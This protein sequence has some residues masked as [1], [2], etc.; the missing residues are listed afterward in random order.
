MRHQWPIEKQPESSGGNRQIADLRHL[1]ALV[2]EIT[3]ESSP[4]ADALNEM[5]RFSSDYDAAPAI[6][7]RRFDAC[8]AETTE[9]AA[10]AVK[11]LNGSGASS[12][13]P[14]AA[15]ARLA[16]ELAR[17]IRRLGRIVV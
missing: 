6:V 13:P 8:A 12:H 11:A 7:Q 17:A 2:Q 14:R 4:S 5:A 3:G 16:D 1:L 15:A 9:W 10:A